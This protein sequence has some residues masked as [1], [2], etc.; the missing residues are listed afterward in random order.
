MKPNDYD[1]YYLN[2][3]PKI[4]PKQ[5]F[6]FIVNTVKDFVNSVNKPVIADV[7][8]ATGDFLLFLK[9][10]FP[11]AIFNGFDIDEL[12]LEKAKKTI[13]G[14]DFGLLDISDKASLPVI[15]FDAVF[16]NGVTGYYEDLA[17]WLPNFVNLI[18]ENGRGYIFGT[19]NTEDV[20]VITRLR[21]PKKSAEF[22]T[23]GC[24][25]SLYTLKTEFKKVGASMNSY[26]FQIDMDI[27]K[28]GED[29][30][31]SW[32]FRDSDGKIVTQNGA[33]IIQNYFLLEVLVDK[34]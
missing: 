34:K 24:A 20:D 31:R 11:E 17:L 13:P 32:T 2:E 33:Q 5:S 14:V 22:M 7:G 6:K 1:R 16:M 4:E 18:S 28:S 29:P 15:K 19:F 10:V 23:F 27:P 30:I 8:C 26:P 3:K 12:L 21:N 25:F 9:S